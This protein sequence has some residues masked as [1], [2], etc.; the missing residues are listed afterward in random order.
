MLQGEGKHVDLVTTNVATQTENVLFSE[1][2]V[3][4]KQLKGRRPVVPILRAYI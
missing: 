1:N 3:G 4:T 2:F